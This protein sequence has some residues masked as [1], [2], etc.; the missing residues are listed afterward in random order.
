MLKKLRALLVAFAI[1]GVV[2]LGIAWDLPLSGDCQSP[3][4]E[5][6]GP[7]CRTLRDTAP[8]II[9]SVWEA[10]TTHEHNMM[11]GLTAIGTLVLA[12]FTFVLSRDAR[13][14]QRAFIAVEPGGIRP[15]EGND[16]RIACD[17]IITNAGNLPARHVSWLIRRK[18]ST[19]AFES[20]FPINDRELVGDIVIAP[21]VPARKGGPPLDKDEFRQ[22]RETAEEDRGWLY[23]WGII[24]YHDGFVPNRQIRFCH[25]YNLRGESGMA[26]TADKARYHEHGNSTEED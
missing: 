5:T 19:D 21:R 10:T 20:D 1:L 22:K 23:V 11:E 17:I 2:Y 16:R 8:D 3:A 13:R 15:F 18:F 7:R 12:F 25:R 4:Q 9:S 6:N 26:I 14:T 24:Q